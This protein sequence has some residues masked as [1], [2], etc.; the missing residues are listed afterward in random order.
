MQEVP[1][2][3]MLQ[4]SLVDLDLSAREGTE[5]DMIV[6]LGHL[7]CNEGLGASQEVFGQ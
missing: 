4:E 7:I 3:R 2:I 5:D 1:H 6:F